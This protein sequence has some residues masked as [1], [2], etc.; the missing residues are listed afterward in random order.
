MVWLGFCY[1]EA[2]KLTGLFATFGKCNMFMYPTY[3]DP[4]NFS[5]EALLNDLSERVKPRL[6]GRNM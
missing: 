3:D 5:L 1:K 6:I 4:P 2:N